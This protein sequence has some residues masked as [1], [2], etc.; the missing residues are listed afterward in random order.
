MSGAAGPMAGASQRLRLFHYWRSSASWRA[1]F[2]L[3]HKQVPVEFAHVN[4][5]DGSSESP[6]YLKRNPMGYVPTL[7]IVDAAAGKPRFIA[8]STAIIEW[9]EETHP[10]HPLLPTDPLDRARARQLAQL[11]NSGTQPLIN[12]GVASLHTP[13]EAGQKT[14]N[15]HWIR[16]GL[17]AFEELVGETAGRFS[18]GDELTIADICL[19]PQCYSAGRFDITL[20]AYPAIAR[21]QAEAAKL[22]A[23]QASHPDRFKPAT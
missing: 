7:E 13:D 16:K 19:I 11:I 22:G 9:L 1:R 21:I 15:Q 2:A 5:L 8:E 23:Y 14:W 4:L 17:A 18:V 12:L 20:E 10:A 6:E 3:A